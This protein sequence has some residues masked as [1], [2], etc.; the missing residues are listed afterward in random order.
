MP[1]EE[2]KVAEADAKLSKMAQSQF[3]ESGKV[4]LTKEMQDE[5]EKFEKERADAN[6]RSREID[7]ELAKEKEQKIKEEAF[8][9]RMY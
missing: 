5:V 2:E 6:K 3:K 1:E 7:K 8:K 9:T 4:T